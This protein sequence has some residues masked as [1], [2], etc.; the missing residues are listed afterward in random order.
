[1]HTRKFPAALLTLL[2][3][4][5]LAKADNWPQWR[6]PN[7]NGVCQEKN[8]PTKW[9]KQTNVAWRVPMPGPAGST[10]AVWEDKIFVTSV[11]GNDL[12]LICISTAGKILWSEKNA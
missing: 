9:D 3:V 2:F 11:D 5:N 10:P 12:L 1:M 7:G 8:L 4:F 6:G